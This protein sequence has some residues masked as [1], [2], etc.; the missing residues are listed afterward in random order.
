[1]IPKNLSNITPKIC[2]SKSLFKNFLILFNINKL[3]KKIIGIAITA[4]FLTLCL[5]NFVPTVY[6]GLFTSLAMIFAMI[7]VL[8]TLPS[9]LKYQK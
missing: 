2:L 7:G 3:I 8:I 9:I 5:S 1:M 4:G 6:F